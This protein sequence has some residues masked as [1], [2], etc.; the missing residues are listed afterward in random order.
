MSGLK[1]VS[2]A[3]AGV[4]LE[5]VDG[6]NLDGVVVS[7]LTMVDVRAPI[8]LRLGN[9]GRDMDTPVPGTFRNVSISNITATQASLAC[10]IAGIPGHPIENVTIS[11]VR[12]QFLGGNPRQPSYVPVPEKVEN[13][14]ESA[15]FGPLPAYAWF[16][17][18]A[19][20]LT[21]SDIEVSYEPGFWRL[22][23]DVY[24]DIHW[25]EGNEP[26]SHSEPGDAG[27]ALFVED[28]HGLSIDG[29]RARASGD[30]AAL[31]R[32]VDVRE[33]LLRGIL[34]MGETPVLLEVAGAASA[35]ISLAENALRRVKT[36]VVMIEGVPGDA[37]EYARGSGGETG[38]TETG[39]DSDDHK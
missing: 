26:P 21:I 20:N 33:A 19:N 9:R 10:S 12:I 11:Q 8:F 13:Y 16:I 4:A 23:T 36:P 7:N 35:E 6:S 25:P 30:G 37:V 38:V 22:T 29:L 31:M 17:R 27:H 2:P 39:G 1:G 32:L 15:M 5:S 14:P 3:L 24:R 18:H 28:V 34:P